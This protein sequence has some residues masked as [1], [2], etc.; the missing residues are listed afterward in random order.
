M[1]CL[2]LGAVTVV[3]G[4]AILLIDLLIHNDDE[5]SV[6][7]RKG[8]YL[9]T[10]LIVAVTAV[11]AWLCLPLLPLPKIDMPSISHLKVIKIG[12]LVGVW[13]FGI[14]FLCGIWKAEEGTPHCAAEDD[15]GC[16]AG[17]IF[18]VVTIGLLYYTLRMVDE[19]FSI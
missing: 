10:W 1:S 2:H 16:T 5:R 14:L 9:Y 15:D 17:C 13:I 18:G 4:L 8:T 19:V 11:T 6:G 7:S 3:I 12:Q